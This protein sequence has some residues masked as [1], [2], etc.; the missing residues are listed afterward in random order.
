MVLLAIGRVCV[1]TTGSEAGRYCVVVDIKD[2]NYVI[3]SGPKSTSG[4][5]RRACNI[6]HLEPLEIVVKIERGADDKALQ[7]ALDSAGLT[8]RFRKRVTLSLE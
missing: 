6:H 5:R 3:V 8:E 1:K 4:V 7:T 2:D